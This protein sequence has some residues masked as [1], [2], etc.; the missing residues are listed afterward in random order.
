M[1]GIAFSAITSITSQ[2]SQGI[3][4]IHDLP[5]DIV[6]GQLEALLRDIRPKAVKVGLIRQAGI[7]RTIRDE[8]VGCRHIV[9]AP[10]I[11][12]SRGEQLMTTEAINEYARFLFPITSTLVLKCSEAEFLF[13]KQISSNDDMLETAERL[14]DMGP[15]SVFLRGG[16]C[17][18]G[19]VTGLLAVADSNVPPQFFTS[20]NT[21]G[22]QLHGVGGTLS[23]AIA[24]RLAMGD[25]IMSALSSAHKYLR[26]QVVYSVSSTSHSLRQMELYNRFMEKV[27]THCRKSHDISF[28][29]SQLNITPRYLS[30]ITRYITGNSPK[31]LIADYLIKEIETSLISTDKTIQEIS[32]DFGFPSQAALAKFFKTYRGISPSEFRIGKTSYAKN[33]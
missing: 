23:S 12:S 31:H 32:I 21:E 3:H 8:I 2:D 25:D 28:Y 13:G 30:E 22:W 11:L 4:N 14:F 26:C 7:I 20:P 10:G 16:H 6:I 19:L 9:S 29:A 5:E 15:K 1:G 18:E 17:T 24:T 27:T 33:K